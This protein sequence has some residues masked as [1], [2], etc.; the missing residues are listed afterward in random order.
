[1]S[2]LTNLFLIAFLLSRAVRPSVD[3]RGFYGGRQRGQVSFDW[4]SLTD[5]PHSVVCWVDRAPLPSD[6]VF[7]AFFLRISYRPYSVQVDF[8]FCVLRLMTALD[9]VLR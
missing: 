6:V 7:L 1:M 5:G 8:V 2:I 9:R 3:G 4:F